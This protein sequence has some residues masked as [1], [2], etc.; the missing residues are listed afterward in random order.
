[1]SRQTD[2]RILEYRL[3]IHSPPKVIF[4]RNDEENIHGTCGTYDIWSM[5]EIWPRISEVNGN[6]PSKDNNIDVYIKSMFNLLNS[7]S[8]T[9]YKYIEISKNNSKVLLTFP[10]P[11]SPMIATNS[12]FL[13]LK[14]RSFKTG[15]FPF[16]YT[17]NIAYIEIVL[18]I[19]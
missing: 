19:Y 2:S 5:P 8:Q 10:L 18:L 1:M 6:S 15:T 4:C 12:P 17:C 3:G 11:T 9:I 7:C 16:I 14:F 13:T